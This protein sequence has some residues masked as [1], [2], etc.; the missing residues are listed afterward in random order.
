MQRWAAG[1]LPYPNSSGLGKDLG[2][3]PSPSSRWR[4]AAREAAHG[5]PPVEGRGILG[6][7]RLSGRRD[8]STEGARV[9]VLYWY[10]S[11]IQDPRREPVPTIPRV[12]GRR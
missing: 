12:E 3:G 9:R 5:C 1:S 6:S 2:P 4:I 7:W 11:G 10:V 8:A